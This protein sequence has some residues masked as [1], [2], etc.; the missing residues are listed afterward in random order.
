V[1][2][3]DRPPRGELHAGRRRRRGRGL[4]SPHGGGEI[5]PGRRRR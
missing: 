3:V 2:A 5:D 1:E 4:G